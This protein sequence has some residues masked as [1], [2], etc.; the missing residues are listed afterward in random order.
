MPDETFTGTYPQKGLI[1]SNP[2]LRHAQ[3]Q[4]TG[5]LGSHAAGFEKHLRELGYKSGDRLL[6]LM[7]E[8]SQWLAENGLGASG[9]TTTSAEKFLSARRVEVGSNSLSMRGLA[10]V[11]DYLVSINVIAL[12]DSADPK[13]PTGLL[14]ARY[15]QYLIEQRGLAAPSIRNYVEVANSFLLYLAMENEAD[16]AT[17]ATPAITQF[18]LAEC[19]RCK[20]SSAKSTTTRLRSL[21]RFLHTEG[22]IAD[23]LDKAV[24]SVAS[25]RLSSLPKM[26]KPAEMARLLKSCDRRT[27]I[28]RRDFA[29]LTLLS[30]LGLR[31]GEVARLQL[32]DVDWAQGELTILG[33]GG[34]RDRLPMPIDVGDAIVGWLCR[35]RP[36]CANKSVF[37]T[38]RAPR[39][40][41]SSGGISA[42]VS[43]ACDRAGVARVGAHR[44]RHTAASTIL[45]AGGTLGEVGQV[46]RHNDHDTT[47]IYAKVDRRALVA[48]VQPWPGSR[49]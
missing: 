39:R 14:I 23:A 20:A 30:R 10:P 40:E 8:M 27:A 32:A 28:G 44:L 18:I 29:V 43:R 9:L 36:R 35:G 26:L 38:T 48:V 13:T 25:W 34:R 5:P 45:Q 12:V 37:L 16:L 19:G 24:L 21:L 11:L 47:S 7:A 1:M 33:K 46:L 6:R 49:P 3:V 4:T 2:K 17:L 22:L 42:I 15:R 31:A 41:L